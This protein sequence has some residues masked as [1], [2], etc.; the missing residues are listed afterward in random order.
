MMDP[1]THNF[2]PNISGSG[3]IQE[4]RRKKMMRT[5]PLKWKANCQ[6]CRRPGSKNNDGG[7]YRGGEATRNA[8]AWL[9]QIDNYPDS[10]SGNPQPPFRLPEHTSIVDKFSHKVPPRAAQKNPTARAQPVGHC[11]PC[12]STGHKQLPSLCPLFL[13]WM[14]AVL[15]W[16]CFD[17]DVEKFSF[18]A[19]ISGEITAILRNRIVME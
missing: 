6:I 2:P 15:L 5:K 16:S 19:D 14:K 1:V 8:T 13:S 9:W 4:R 7:R 17:R 18:Q 3:K 11:C 10:R 12:G